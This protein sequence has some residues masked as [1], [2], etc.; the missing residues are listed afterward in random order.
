M[1]EV[2]KT[3]WLIRIL[4]D[5]IWLLSFYLSRDFF[6]QHLLNQCYLPLATWSQQVNSQVQT[7][8]HK[9]LTTPRD[10]SGKGANLSCANQNLYL[11]EF[12]IEIKQVWLILILQWWVITSS[13]L[14]TIENIF[15]L[16]RYANL[17]NSLETREERLTH[18]GKR[19]EM[20]A[21][22]R[23]FAVFTQGFSLWIKSLGST[24]YL[25]IVW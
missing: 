17:V 21:R 13:T 22:G 7:L 11:Q 12:G 15:T 16:W 25:C 1:E 2:S 20:R 3:V 18:T 5:K 6:I 4:A 23:N 8:K 24:R 10:V 9:T 19:E 14:D